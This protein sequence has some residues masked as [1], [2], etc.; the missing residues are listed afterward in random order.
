[1]PSEYSHSNV[2]VSE[3]EYAIDRVVAAHRV[4]AR[5]EGQLLAKA[6]ND[7]EFVAADLIRS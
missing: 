2:R 5:T 1:M 7:G 3:A 6:V 4:S